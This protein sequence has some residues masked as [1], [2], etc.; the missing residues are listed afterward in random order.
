M[1]ELM[2]VPE[3]AAGA[4][5]VLIQEWLVATGAAVTKGEPLVVVETDKAVVEVEAESDGVLLRA[6]VD[7][8][9]RA[10]VGSPLALV[11]TEAEA[12]RDVDELLAGIGLGTAETAGREPADERASDPAPAGPTPGVAPGAVSAA[13][14]AGARRPVSPIARRLLREAGL[15]VNAVTG[16]GPG[17]RVTRRDVQAILRDRPAELTSAAEP[18]PARSVVAQP[19]TG[20]GYTDV[21]H[22]RLRLA[23]ATRL[24]E[25]KREVPH[26]YV[27]RAVRIDELLDLR[28]RL[29]A[30]GDARVSVND[31]VLKAVAVAHRTIPDANV[32]WT[33]EALRHFDRVDLAVA[34]ASPRGLVTPVLRAVESMSLSEISRRV[35]DFAEQAGSGRLQQRDLEGGSVSVS[36]LGMY[37]VD[38][39]AAIINPPHSMILAVGAG[40]PAPV[41]EEV[42]G[43]QR[44]VPATVMNLTAS[45]DHRAVDGALAAQWMDVLVK[46]LESPFGLVL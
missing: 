22:S 4:A 33:D 35:K 44:I 45:V 30:A 9:L 43:E 37:G 16:S 11:G 20:A 25:S 12:A 39:F 28:R 2:R 13:A 14:P 23:I 21:P 5:D 7:A 40:R 38:E 41:V 26:F 6:L 32:I 18:T 15:D 1:A 34:I 42:D 3:V 24:G 36:N 29:N 27:R 31:L 17:G 8:G 19:V 46:V 10:D